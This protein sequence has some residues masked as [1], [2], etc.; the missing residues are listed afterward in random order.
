MASLV[1]DDSSSASAFRSNGSQYGSAEVP[2][3]HD[4][5]LG[6]GSGISNH[7]G[8]IKFRKLVDKHKARYIAASRVDK[9]RY[10][11][12]FVVWNSLL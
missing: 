4:V 1:S 11:L 9:V 10:S 3:P 7:V 5:L 6:R 12:L 8:N 2:G